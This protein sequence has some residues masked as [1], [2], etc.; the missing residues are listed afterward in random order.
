[1][2]CSA[3]VSA[4]VATDIKKYP[5]QK[6][7]GKVSLLNGD[8]SVVM[9]GTI[10]PVGQRS[11]IFGRIRMTPQL[12]IKSSED[13]LEYDQAAWIA[14]HNQQVKYES[15]YA[16][17][18]VAAKAYAESVQKVLDADYCSS[19]SSHSSHYSRSCTPPVQRTTVYGMRNPECEWY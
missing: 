18:P 19:R 1:M 8:G 4:S 10:V 13:G 17:D 9:T 11:Q 3:S 6:E 5:F 14:K 12:K 15:I 16:S 2:G 7:F